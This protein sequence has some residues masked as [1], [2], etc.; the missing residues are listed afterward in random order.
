M[1]RALSAE[2]MKLKRASTVLWTL[3]AVALWPVMTV[4]WTLQFDRRLESTTW[5]SFMHQAPQSMASW[6]GFLIFGLMASYLFARELA[7]GTAKNML[8]L[9]VRREWFVVA[10]MVVLALM[11]FGLAALSVA[12]H[13][14]WAAALGLHGFAW[15]HVWTSMGEA[16]TIALLMYLTLPVVASLAMLERGYLPPMLFSSLVAG[17][18][19]MPMP[20]WW[21]RWFPWSMPQALAGSF[22][23]PGLAKPTLVAGSWVVATAVFVVGLTAV[24]LYVDRA[25]NVQ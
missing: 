21:C 18:A 7:D 19:L 6:W 1:L 25:D 11:V 22:I 23:G 5:D 12:V 10:K 15:E 2:F 16:M 3:L 13:V 4:I 14:V 17:V 24:I 8:T 20:A 9:P